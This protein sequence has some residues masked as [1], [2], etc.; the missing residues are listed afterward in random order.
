MLVVKKVIKIDE[1]VSEE[2]VKVAEIK[3]AAVNLTSV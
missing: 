2:T 1:K 3:I